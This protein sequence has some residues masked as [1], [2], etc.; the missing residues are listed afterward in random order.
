[1]TTHALPELRTLGALYEQTR[2][3][4]VALVRDVAVDWVDASAFVPA[5]AGWRV[6]DVIAH[7]SGLATD[8]ESGNLD[9]AATDAWTAAQVDARRDLS[10]DE[11]LRESDDVGPKLASFLDDF[12]G[13]YGA[14]VV[15][16]V[17]VHEQDIRGA[18]RRPGARDSAAVAHCL[19]F[20]LATLVGPGARAL[21]LPPLQIGA[22]T[23][24]VVVGGSEGTVAD[25]TEAIQT[26]LATWS[27][28]PAAGEETAPCSPGASLPQLEATPFDLVRA[29]TGRR[30]LDQVHR[31]GWSVDPAP[32]AALFGLWPFTQRSVDL[33]E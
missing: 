8:I 7:L 18:L 3:R 1:M 25:P 16:D 28:P 23:R 10:V 24:V 2:Q 15:A 6:R 31:F 26:A 13:R 17:A 5:C 32:Y 14:Q 12:P 29:F 30:S 33:V 21:G 19:D 27:W 9:G 4:V 20:L 22:G 11:V